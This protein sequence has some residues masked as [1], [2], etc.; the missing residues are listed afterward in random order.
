MGVKAANFVRTISI[1]QSQRGKKKN[2]SKFE[3][4][5]ELNVKHF[6]SAIDESETESHKRAERR[7][8]KDRHRGRAHRG[9]TMNHIEEKH[10]ED[11]HSDKSDD[12]NNNQKDDSHDNA[13]LES[14]EAA[15]NLSV[16]ATD[17]PWPR[18]IASDSP[19]VGSDNEA[20]EED[21]L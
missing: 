8:K 7:R 3:S 4:S 16:D 11:S 17:V 13:V 15:S 5:M 10:D 1:L 20:Y 6:G 12:S 9:D 21:V 14:S 19:L 18:R 2:K